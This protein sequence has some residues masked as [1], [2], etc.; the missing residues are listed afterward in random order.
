MTSLLSRLL[1]AGSR[2][3]EAEKLVLG[4][5]R[6]RLDPSIAARWDQQVRAINKIQRLPEGVEVNF[7]RMKQGRPSFDG[8]LAF[9]NK[10]NE[11]L[12]AKVRLKLPDVGHE[13]VASVWSIKGFVFSIEYSSSVNYFE[14]ALGMDPPQKVV[15][16]CELMANL[17]AVG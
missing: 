6:D 4:C 2:L 11:L 17:A 5:V 16:S 12:V 10:A 3:S 14:E 13:I 7:Y 1:G 9:P 8:A 15:V